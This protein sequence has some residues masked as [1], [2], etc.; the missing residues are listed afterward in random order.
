LVNLFIFNLFIHLSNNKRILL[1]IVFAVA[2]QIWNRR[3]SSKNFNEYDKLE[4]LKVFLILL[5]FD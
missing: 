4:G 1:S 3:K 2:Y 5:L